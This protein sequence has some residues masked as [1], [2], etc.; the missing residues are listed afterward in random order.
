[1]DDPVNPLTTL[2]PRFFAV[3]AA[4]FIVSTAQALFFS[5]LPA[6]E[7]GAKPSDRLSLFGSQTSCPAR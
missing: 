2:T 5:G 1:M 3:L 4:F 6:H 7:G